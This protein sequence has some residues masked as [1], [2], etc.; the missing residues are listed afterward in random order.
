MRPT[1]TEAELDSPWLLGQ[2]TSIR[3]AGLGLQTVQDFNGQAARYRKRLQGFAGDIPRVL[4]G[5]NS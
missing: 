3:D 4:Q 5:G 1:I 2:A